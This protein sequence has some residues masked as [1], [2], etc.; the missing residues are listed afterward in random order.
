MIKKRR[1]IKIRISKISSKTKQVRSPQL[2]SPRYKLQDCFWAFTIGDADDKPSVPHA[3]AIGVGYRLD[4]WTG[5]IYP[6]GSER[7]KSIGQIKQKE[8]CKLHSDPGFLSFAKK[9]IAWYKSEYP[10]IRFYVPEWFSVNSKQ[11]RVT[12]FKKQDEDSNFIF[13]GRCI[14]N[15]K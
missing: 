1:L 11:L 8:L 9:Q 12:A 15:H 13:Y 10:T 14:I 4:A 3:H 2:Y 5:Y 6:A 7:K